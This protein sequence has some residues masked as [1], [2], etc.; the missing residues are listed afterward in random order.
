MQDSNPTIW[1]GEDTF[2]NMATDALQTTPL[3]TN[4]VEVTLMDGVNSTTTT[5]VTPANSD[6]NSGHGN[7]SNGG[8]GNTANE[9]YLLYTAP[10]YR[11]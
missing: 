1:D 5:G 9:M 10:G 3:N 11:G 8:G 2:W 7:A 6:I 4:G